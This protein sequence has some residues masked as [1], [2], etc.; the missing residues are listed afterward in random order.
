MDAINLILFAVLF[1]LQVAILILLLRRRTGEAAGAGPEPK[2]QPNPAVGC[3][4]GR[5]AKEQ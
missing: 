3:L 1:V 4:Y 2:R 5:D